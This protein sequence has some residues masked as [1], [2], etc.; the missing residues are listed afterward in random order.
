MLIFIFNDNRTIA[1]KKVALTSGMKRVTYLNMMLITY[2]SMTNYE[3]FPNGPIHQMDL[4]TNLYSL[5]RY[6]ISWL[7]L[8][9]L[10]VKKVCPDFPDFN[11]GAMLYWWTV[12]WWWES[13]VS[14]NWAKEGLY[15][16]LFIIMVSYFVIRSLTFLTRD[17]L[18]PPNLKHQISLKGSTSNIILMAKI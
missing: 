7:K 14:K 8:S 17:V 1:Q 4:S 5:E 13:T 11:S 3:K 9:E 18:N 12:C 6:Q 2:F 16:M 15:C 10:L